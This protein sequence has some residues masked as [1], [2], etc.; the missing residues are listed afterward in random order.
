MD[1]YYK[2]CVTHSRLKPSI[3]A[4]TYNYYMIMKKINQN[5]ATP[6][7]YDMASLLV[8]SNYTIKEYFKEC[9]VYWLSEPGI[10]GKHFNPIS[11]WY[12]I[13][14]N[15]IQTIL[16][17]VTNT[18]WNEKIL[19]EIPNDDVTKV[20]KLMH[21]SPFNPQRNQ[22]YLF[23]TNQTRGFE[24]DNLNI[25][26]NILLYDRDDTLVLYVDMKLKKHRK[27]LFITFNFIMIIIYIYYQALLMW[28][29]NFPL[30]SHEP[31]RSG[32]EYF[33]CKNN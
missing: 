33:T 28:F 6:E 1:S 17:T 20:W 3:N 22:Y 13:K 14:D 27:P 16:V 30:Y 15:I 31:R 18:P 9:D 21:V 19:Y 29:R 10:F 4:F 2:G 24:F 11:F 5:S 7:Y 25:N 32:N 23:K 8:R 26:W 12:F